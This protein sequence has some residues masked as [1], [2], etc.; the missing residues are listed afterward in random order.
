MNRSKQTLHAL[1]LALA[2]TV[3]LAAM[4]AGAGVTIIAH[5]SVAASSVT[6]DELQAMFTGKTTTWSDGAAANPAVLAEG[7]VLEEFLKDYVKKS[8]AQFGT[9]WKK[10]VFSGTGTPPEELKTEADLVAFVARTPGA[11]GFVAAGTATGGAKVIAV[12]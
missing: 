4:P 8:A 2:A 3:V 12:Q 11:I 5:P 9:F 7:P 10:A 1:A 6:A